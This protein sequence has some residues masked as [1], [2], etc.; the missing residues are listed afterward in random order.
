MPEEIK[1]KPCPFCG[2]STVNDTTYQEP[3]TFESGET[4]FTIVCPDC[5]IPKVEHGVLEKAIEIW[6]K[7]ANF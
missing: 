1:L 7:R 4:L 6:N 5:V 2:E 3:H